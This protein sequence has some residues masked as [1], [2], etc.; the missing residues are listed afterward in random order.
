VYRLVSLALLNGLTALPSGNLVDGWKARLTI[1]FVNLPPWKPLRKGGKI[2]VIK[3]VGQVSQIKRRSLMQS[4]VTTQFLR[5]Y[6]DGSRVKV[7]TWEYLA[8]KQ[9]KAY[10][11]IH[12]FGAL[13]VYQMVN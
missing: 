7:T 13:V 11:Q 4:L 3:S 5:E 9:S 6:P 12:A 10:R 1:V 8:D 2:P